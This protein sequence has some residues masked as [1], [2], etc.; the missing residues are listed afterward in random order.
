MWCNHNNHRGGSNELTNLETFYAF[1]PE[2]DQ[3][4]GFALPQ[5]NAKESAVELMMAARIISNIK[6]N[7]SFSLKLINNVGKFLKSS[8][9]IDVPEPGMLVDNDNCLLKSLVAKKAL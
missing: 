3:A 6:N 4:S 7:L 2:K 8:H 5:T 1:A 9:E